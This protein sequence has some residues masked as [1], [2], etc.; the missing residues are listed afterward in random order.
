MHRALVSSGLKLSRVWLPSHAGVQGNEKADDLKKAAHHATVPES[1]AVTALNYARRTLQRHLMAP[2]P[3]RRSAS[4]RPPF[5]LL[6][7]ELTRQQW[8][9]LLRIGIGCSWMASWRYSKGL[10][11]PSACSACG[12][13]ETVKHLLCFCPAFSK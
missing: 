4:G 2:H 8:S 7:H 9:L 13:A 5:P 6:D 12:E 10:A 11:P 3:D 1:T